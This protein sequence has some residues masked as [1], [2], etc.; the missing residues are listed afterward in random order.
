MK[1]GPLFNFPYKNTRLDGRGGLV[2]QFFG[3]SQR[4]YMEILGTNGHN[5]IDFAVPNGTEIIAPIDMF[6]SQ[7]GIDSKGGI[8]FV[9]EVRE[10]QNTR[11]ELIFVH[12]KINLVVPGIRIKKGEVVAI[13]DNTGWSS[14][15][16]LHFGVRVETYDVQNNA[17]FRINNNNKGYIDPLPFFNENGYVYSD[18]TMPLTIKKLSGNKDVWAIDA[19]NKRHLILNNE[20]FLN[21]YKMGLWGSSPLVV[22][23]LWEEESNVIIIVKSE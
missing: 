14:G 16:H 21:G 9:G 13:S 19:Q 23:K 7:S 6:I 18:L 4:R 5:G 3:E 2:S 1:L 20:T 15:P 8:Y 10:D 17:W 22:E 11:Y 12:N